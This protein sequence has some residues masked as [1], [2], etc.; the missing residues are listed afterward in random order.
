MAQ[1]VWTLEVNMEFSAAHALRHYQGKCEKLHGHNYRVR[2]AVKGNELLPKTELLM[3]FGDLKRLVKEAVAPLDHANIND[4]PPFDGMNASSENLSRYIW[5]RI[6]PVLPVN[7][8]LAR[9][10]VAERDAQS[11]TYSEE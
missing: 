4:V 1:P 2:V 8:R 10:T 7:V 3:D 11:A 6:A 9:V 5:Q